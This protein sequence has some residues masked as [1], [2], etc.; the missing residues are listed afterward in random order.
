MGVLSMTIQIAER[1]LTVTKQM[2]K[3]DGFKLFMEEDY[4]NAVAK[5]LNLKVT[6]LA[7]WE[8]KQPLYAVHSPEDKI[9]QESELTRIY[10]VPF[11]E[12]HRPITE[13]KKEIMQAIK[14]EDDVKIFVKVYWTDENG[15]DEF[16][17]E[18]NYGLDGD[19]YTD[20]F[21]NET[22]FKEEDAMKRAKALHRT[23][24]G[25]FTNSDVVVDEK[26]EQ[27]HA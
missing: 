13:I 5:E 4:A 19:F 26:I 8:T 6:V 23:V 12:M 16:D 7:D 20:G 15:K 18:I 25:W 14:Y 22:Y 27:Y 11:K 17:V 3:E 24:K 9:V 10:P 2:I 21:T 1:V